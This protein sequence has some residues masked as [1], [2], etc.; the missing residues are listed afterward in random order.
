M[1][2]AA[3]LLLLLLLTSLARG[4]ERN[5]LLVL[6]DDVGVDRVACYGLAPD[7]PATPNLDRFAA[8]GLRFTNA[9][10]QPYCGPSRAAL[11]TGRYGF[12]T[13]IGTNVEHGRGARG[14]ELEEWTIPEVL[15]AGSERIRTGA[16]GKWHLA[17]FEQGDHH[18]VDQGFERTR[19]TQGNLGDYFTF[20][21]TIDGRSSV[22]VEGYAT[23]DSVDDALQ[24]IEEFGD[25]PW[26]LY[27]PLHA[28]HVPF[29]A[30]P[31]DLRSRALE[32]DP[33]ESAAA[34]HKA[35]V[36]AADRELGRLWSSLPEAVR[37]R[38]TLIVVGD[39]GTP[40][41]AVEAPFV[42]DHA[43]GTLFEGSLHVPWIVAGA[44]VAEPGVVVALV[45]TV[46]LLPTV[47]GLMGVDPKDVL[48][49]GRVLDG[50]DLGPLLRDPSGP[51]RPVLFAERFAPNHL[52]QK[53]QS[54]RA[55]RD[56][57][58]K[59]IRNEKRGRDKLFDLAGDPHEE[60]DL[61]AEE[62]LSEEAQRAYGRLASALDEILGG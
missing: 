52:P 40:R 41:P 45:S 27:L 34:H 42:P 46:D 14:L 62:E 4:Q 31:E 2:T 5:V 55:V 13:G 32:G 8:E 9:W 39:N 60:Q 57:R 6:L 3:L 36:E 23:S 37:G 19:L 38:T 33:E 25:A 28:S 47:C 59:L 7:P 29:H 18:P 1:R 51:G 20:K 49:E 61:M 54:W 17:S 22:M 10:A 50:H 21:K 53:E 30:P 11:L 35:A 48:P 26:F 16:C 56:G 58:F 43:K 15:R 44:G 24:V 12:R